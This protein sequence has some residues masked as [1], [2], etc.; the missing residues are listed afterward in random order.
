MSKLAKAVLVTTATVIILLLVLVGIS[1]VSFLSW[2]P[3]EQV[4]VRELSAD[5]SKIALFS[6]RY[7]GIRPWLPS[8]IEPYCYVTIV[9][10]KSGGII[11]RDTEYHSG[12]MKR[13]F[14]ELAR[15]HAPWAVDTIAAQL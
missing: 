7:Q 13:M 5:G 4:Y 10:A 8:D 1:W 9:D 6:I 2:F 15:K 14:T 3:S 12:G 11:F